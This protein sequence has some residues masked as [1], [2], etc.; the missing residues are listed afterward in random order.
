V[1]FAIRDLFLNIDSWNE[2]GPKQRN[3]QASLFPSRKEDPLADLKEKLTDTE[4][5][6]RRVFKLVVEARNPE[7]CGLCTLKT[8]YE[9]AL[10]LG[11]G[12]ITR[13]L[14]ERN[15]SV[16]PDADVLRRNIAARDAIRQTK[17]RSILTK[18]MLK[19]I[20]AADKK[21]VDKLTNEIE[22]EKKSVEDL[23]GLIEQE[24]IALDR[25][26][27]PIRHLLPIDPDIPL[28][29]LMDMTT[30]FVGNGP[31]LKE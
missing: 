13:G 1:N 10:S 24:E 27:A 2:D 11:L 17:M 16:W 23:T 12:D 5:E 8:N 18:E 3:T 31:Y 29:N 30:C 14:L 28:R 15:L 7:T 25:L 20:K 19:Q 21:I 26:I 4:K 22:A 6:F 9:I